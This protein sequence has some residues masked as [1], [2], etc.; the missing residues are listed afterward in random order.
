MANIIEKI[1]MSKIGKDFQIGDII[2]IPVDWA[3]VHDGTMVLTRKHFL[4]IA[5]KVFDPD[6]IFVIFDHLYPPNNENTANLLRVSREFVSKQNITNFFEGGNGICHQIILENEQVKPGDFLVGADSHSSTAGAK[7]CLSMGVGATDMAYIFAT[8]KT[9]IRIPG[10]I[11]VKLKGNLKANCSYKDA[12]LEL[13]G[14]LKV[15]GTL[16][17]G[18]VFE[19][20]KAMSLEDR[21]TLCNM[22]VEIGSKFTIFEPV[23]AWLSHLR[24]DGDL[25]FTRIIEI[26]LDDIEPNV[27][28]PHDIDNVKKVAALD[29]KKIDVAFIGTCTGGR[30]SN[31]MAAEEILRG[32]KV[33]KNVRLLICPASKTVLSEI[34]KSGTLQS[35]LDAGAVLLP[36]GCGPCLGGHLGVLGE[37]EMAISTANRNFLGRMGSKHS[38]IFLA[39]AKTVAMSALKGCIINAEE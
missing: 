19:S 30:P 15:D 10:A 25:D 32:K 17:Q 1:I 16:N 2:E 7:Y 31:F 13:A 29:K 18:L 22:G 3:M 12:F 4:T 23:E 8:G 28:C 37:N 26:N 35:L 6:K 5:D 36:P 9:W 27:A 33:H 20:E 14:M 38:A 39:S 34:I 11:K 24:S 21:A